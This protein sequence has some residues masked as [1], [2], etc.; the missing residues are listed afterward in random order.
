MLKDWLERKPFTA[1]NLFHL[2]PALERCKSINVTQI[3]ILAFHGPIQR[4]QLQGLPGAPDPVK[5][6]SQR[7]ESFIICVAESLDC[8]RN[9]LI[10]ERRIVLNAK[11][12]SQQLML[13]ARIGMFFQSICYFGE[14]HRGCWLRGCS[15]AKR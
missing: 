8:V 7:S 11:M 2:I 3:K 5:P 1:Q 13:G 12:K 10:R 14:P 9:I 15:G 6:R 4:Q